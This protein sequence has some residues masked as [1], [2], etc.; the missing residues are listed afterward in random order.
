MGAALGPP[1]IL[2]R[3][4]TVADLPVLRAL[5]AQLQATPPWRDEQEPAARA[6]MEATM[7][8]P[9]RD[10]LVAE[11]DGRVVAM[12][13]VVIVR[14]LSHGLRPWATFENLAVDPA[15][16]R[17]GIARALIGRATDIARER[18]CYKAQFLSGATRVEAH[19]VYEA[20]GFDF[21]VRGFRRY[22]EDVG[23]GDR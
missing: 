21:P 14:N 11:A 7:A 8:D 4:A 23:A 10:L 20:A 9:D 17:R 22:L 2:I 13:D 15:H 19:R 16:R 6:L 12:L 18:G 1:T 5:F 3:A